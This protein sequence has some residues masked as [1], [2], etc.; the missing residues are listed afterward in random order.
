MPAIV[1]GV[2]ALIENNIEVLTWID[3]PADAAV[4][5]EFV[6]VV[7]PLVGKVP[8]QVGGELDVEIDLH[9]PNGEIALG[10]ADNV[11]FVLR[12]EIEMGGRA[13]PHIGDDFG[14]FPIEKI[15]Q[16]KALGWD[17]LTVWQ[18]E[19]KDTDALTTRL[20]AFLDDVDKSRSGS[21][22]V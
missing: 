21:A 15:A 6:G 17:V 4:E 1:R 11:G 19:T 12:V 10:K 22:S 8:D 9:H 20:N 5:A 7:I 3:G 16:L 14:A 2:N 13:P 18:C